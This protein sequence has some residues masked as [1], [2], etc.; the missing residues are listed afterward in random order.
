MIDEIKKDS[1][2]DEDRVP[3]PELS[4][5]VVGECRGV[6]KGLDKLLRQVEDIKTREQI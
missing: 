2:K 1:V 3:T 6:R 5:A 4:I